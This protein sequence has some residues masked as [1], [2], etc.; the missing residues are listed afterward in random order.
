MSE[1]SLPYR[2]E[3][4]GLRALAVLSV[5]LFH[6]NRQ[7]LPGGFVG[8]DI[9]LVISG[10]LITSILYHDL[11]SDQFGFMKFYQRRIARIFPAFF[12]VALSTITVAYFIYSEHDLARAGSN[13]VA[14]SMSLTNIK[15]MLLGDYF[16]ISLDAEPFMHYWS[17]SI[18]EQYYLLFPLLLFV[19]F[20]YARNYLVPILALILVISL[21]G[22]ILF[23]PVNSVWTFYLLPTRAW[24]LFAGCL[25]AIVEGNSTGPMRVPAWVSLGGVILIGGSVTLIQEG[26]HFPGWLATLPVMGAIALLMQSQGLNYV[27]SWLSTGP[28]VAIGK[29]SYSLYLWHWPVYSMVDYGYLFESNSTRNILKITIS[30]VLAAACYRFIEKPARA[31]LNRPRNHVRAFGALAGA[32]ALS[33][34]LGIGIR[35]SNYVTANYGE[36]ADGGEFFPGKPGAPSVVL[37]GDSNGSM[38]GKVTRDLC[39]DLGYSLNVIAVG[40]QD[41]LPD[42]KLWQD[43]ISFIHKSKPDYLIIA[44]FWKDRLQNSPERLATALKDLS[45]NVGHIILLNQPPTPPDEANRDFIRNGSRPPFKEK[46]GVKSDREFNNDLLLGFQSQKVT[47]V[48]VAKYFENEKGEVLFFDGD[49]NQN[50]HDYTHLSGHGAAK[51]Y[52][53][54]RELISPPG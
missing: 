53:E 47:V 5:I 17:L 30:F 4:D 32:L 28:M 14:A 46:E 45:E 36:V 44:A 27:T 15:Y 13:L 41:P 21:A 2:P 51:I 11:K 42:T 31:Y 18:E 20:R 1:R 19:T 40:A 48:N 52:R 9:F 16:K 12:T 26:P 34:P 50:Y 43:S 24:E 38:Y 35:Y 39:K 7:W 25:L 3:I 8:V 33:I 29:I 49:A 54:V 23:T 6:L 22:C 10:Y 37:M